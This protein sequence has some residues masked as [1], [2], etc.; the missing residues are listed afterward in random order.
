MNI[1]R[2]IREELEGFKDSSQ[3]DWEWSKGVTVDG[4]FD[5]CDL[6]KMDRDIV[7]QDIIITY[8]GYGTRKKTMNVRQTVTAITEPWNENIKLHFKEGS[9]LRT[10]GCGWKF[11]IV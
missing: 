6:V 7:G 3:E 11:S 9:E 1:K 10:I 4:E 5:V 8:G 2:I